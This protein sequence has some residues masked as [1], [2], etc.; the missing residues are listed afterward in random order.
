MEP[1]LAAREWLTGEFSV[2]DILM[3]DVLRLVDRFD[4]LAKHPACKAYV[5]RAKA[6]PAFQKVHADQL[7]FYAAADQSRS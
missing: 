1:Q 7:A 4:G 6:R 2:A 3:S 5:E